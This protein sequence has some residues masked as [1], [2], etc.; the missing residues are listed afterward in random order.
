MMSLSASIILLLP[1]AYFLNTGIALLK[2]IRVAKASKIPYVVV[3]FYTYNRL[4]ALL[5]RYPLGFLDKWSPNPPITS[6]RN[7]VKSNW[8]WKFRHE[9]FVQL[10]TDTFLTVAP[11]GLILYTADASVISQITE[12]G[13]DFPKATHLYTTVDI[14]GKNV[15]SSEGAIWRHH[16][17]VT[18][19]SFTERNNQLVWRETLEQSQAML[20]SWTANGAEKGKTIKTLQG[21]AMKL[22][23]NVISA[24]GLGR[25]MAWPRDD[26]ASRDDKN[27]PNGHTMSFTD[28]IGFLLKNVLVIMILPKWFMSTSPFPEVLQNLHTNNTFTENAPFKF[29]HKCYVAY[30][31]WGKYMSTMVSEKRLSSSQSTAT[32]TDLLTQLSKTPADAKDTS[33]ALTDSEIMGNLFVLIIAGH[34]TSAS[35]IHCSLFLLALHPHIQSVVQADLDRI[36]SSR[37]VS[38]WNYDTDLP[39]LLT[40]HLGAV[41]AE[42]LRLIAP[43]INIPKIVA[44]TPQKLTIEDGKEVTAPLNTMIRLCVPSVHRNPKFWPAGLPATPGKSAFPPGNE[45]NDL[46]EFKPSRWLPSSSTSSPSIYK[47]VK[48]SYIPFSDGARGCLGKRFA[49]VEILAALAVILSQYSVELAV[50]EWAS[51]AEIEKMTEEE[52]ES[53]W[54]KAEESAT[55]CW[56]NK[57]GVVI[58]LQMRGECVP[59]R[60]VR[61][62]AERFRFGGS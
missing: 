15:V 24:A 60:F 47:P 48:G 42:Q 23:L 44:S 46:E 51:D 18:G 7:L 13:S 27:I 11:G 56:Q 5:S 57:M 9:P 4:L 39:A 34:E 12:R 25:K 32:T 55:W 14:Y 40:S 49:Q 26:K 2:N 22:S 41:L 54:K 50:D 28:A 31:E 20:D 1:V 36:F 43:I 16:R 37:P 58:T 45:S 6:W 8:P 53:V 10:G 61:R 62:G 33:P 35:S 29:F 17:K 59:V 3:P 52:R 38:T 19:L 30:D 21:D